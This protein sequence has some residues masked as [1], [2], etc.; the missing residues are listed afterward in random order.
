[1]A[2]HVLRHDNLLHDIVERKMLGKAIC[3][4]KRMELLHDMIEIG[5]YGQLKDL[6]SERSRWRQDS[7]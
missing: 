6:I 4:T 5:D 7:K 1:M 3:S 2:W